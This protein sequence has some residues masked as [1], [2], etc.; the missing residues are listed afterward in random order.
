MTG[1]VFPLLKLFFQ[2]FI[3]VHQ[4]NLVEI[5]EVFMVVKFKIVAFWLITWY[6]LMAGYKPFEEPV[7]SVIVQT[8]KGLQDSSSGW[9]WMQISLWNVGNCLRDLRDNAEDD[10][11]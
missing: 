7:A 9:K 11:M 8:D 4:L 2:W 10:N 6:S 1:I 5:C 3:S